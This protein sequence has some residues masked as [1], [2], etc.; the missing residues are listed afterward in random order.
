M[1]QSIK[2]LAIFLLLGAA[3]V[4]HAMDDTYVSIGGGFVKPKQVKSTSLPILYKTPGVVYVPNQPDVDT[5]KFKQ[6]FSIKGAIGYKVGDFRIEAE[7]SFIK[8][9]YKSFDLAGSPILFNDSYSGYVSLLSGLLNAYADLPVNDVFSPYV[10]IGLGMVHAKNHLEKTGLISVDAGGVV[11]PL[12]TF[13]TSTTENKLAYQGIVGLSLNF[14]KQLT[15]TADY[16]YFAT[17]KLKAFDKKLQTE[18]LT[19]GLSYKF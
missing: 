5:L 15:L 10:G 2:T 16:R 19:V 3:N 17:S 13:K 1:R 7:P 18:S 4:S 14:N 6:G 11:T 8:S 12:P 9:K